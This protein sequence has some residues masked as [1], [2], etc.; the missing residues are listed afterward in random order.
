MTLKCWR[1]SSYIRGQ[2]AAAE[3]GCRCG[4]KLSTHHRA[5]SSAAVATKWPRLYEIMMTASNSRWCST[6]DYTSRVRLRVADMALNE[7][8]D[9]VDESV[10]QAFSIVDQLFVR[11][12]EVPLSN[13]LWIGGVR[14]RRL[15]HS[16]SEVDLCLRTRRGRTIGRRCDSYKS[17]GFSGDTLAVLTEMRV[18]C[19]FARMLRCL[20]FN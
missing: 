10:V 7:T 12:A 20:R 4:R 17:F 5:L 19:H 9:Y 1:P 6:R 2:Y 18:L 11:K 13:P 8:V 15:R 14:R 16:R 3:S